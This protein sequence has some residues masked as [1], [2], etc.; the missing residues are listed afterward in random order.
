M[1]AVA[2]ESYFTDLIFHLKIKSLS[3]SQPIAMCHAYFILILSPRQPYSWRIDE[4]KL[5]SAGQ[6]CAQ[7]E[8]PPA[9]LSRRQP[10][11]T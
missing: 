7:Q 8:E 1:S 6:L 10:E 5:S 11:D 3:H 9:K 2:P 4:R